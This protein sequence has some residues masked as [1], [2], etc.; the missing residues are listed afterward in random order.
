MTTSADQLRRRLS[1]SNLYLVTPARPSAGDLNHFLPAVLEAGVDMVQIRE[2]HLEAGQLMPFLAI[3]KRHTDDFGALLIVN[4]RVD[5]A[6]AASADGVHLGQDDLAPAHARDQ[7]GAGA[8]I[9]L[10]T[11][12]RSEVQSASSEPVDYI[13]V[14]PIHETPTKPGRAGTGLGLIEVAKESSS[15]PFFAIGGIDL[16]TVGDV[17]KAGATRIVVVRALTEADDP[18]SVARRLKAALWGAA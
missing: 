4:D 12:A 16:E 5:V 17:V 15:V 11:H 10:S 7:M 8:L 18:P 13:A 6:I 9:G 2:K 1:D 3:A 14:G